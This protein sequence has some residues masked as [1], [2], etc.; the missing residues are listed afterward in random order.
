MQESM[1]IAMDKTKNNTGLTV[2]V[3]I[4]YGGRHELVQTT[5]KIAKLV[6]DEVVNIE[7]IDDKLISDNLYTAGMPDPDLLIRTSYELRTSNFLPWQI[8]YSEFYFTHKFWPEFDEKEFDLAI[9][10]YKKRNRK[11]G[12]K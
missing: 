4:N 7:E 12:G 3:C 11:F 2:S 9:E 8:V 10:K 6:K 1:K 5:Q